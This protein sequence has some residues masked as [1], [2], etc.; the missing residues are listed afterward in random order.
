LKNDVGCCTFFGVGIDIVGVFIAT[1]VIV[2]VFRRDRQEDGI[3]AGWA[4]G[5]VAGRR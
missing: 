3:L 1:V 4:V 5:R 2:G